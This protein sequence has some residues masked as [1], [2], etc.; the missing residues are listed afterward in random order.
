M[1]ETMMLSLEYPPWA[2]Q[3]EQIMI[4]KE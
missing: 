3:S 2:L 4:I 1:L